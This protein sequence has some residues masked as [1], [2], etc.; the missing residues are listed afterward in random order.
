MKHDFVGR[1]ITDDEFYQLKPR[2]V[3]HKQLE[4]VQL[5]CDEHRNRH[6]L[7]RR[8]FACGNFDSAYI[9]ISADDYYKLYINGVFVAQGPAPGYHFD[10]NY[11]KVDAMIL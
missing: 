3:F 10:Y 2:C 4:P 5:P 9:C 11:N 6:I 1:W 7:F 8:K